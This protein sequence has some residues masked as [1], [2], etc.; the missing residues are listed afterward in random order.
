MALVEI[1]RPTVG[2]LGAETQRGLHTGFFQQATLRP[3]APA[4]ALADRE[5][6]YAEIADEA[7]RLAAALF[8][9]CNRP[10][11]RVGIFAYRSRASYAGTLGAL[12]AGAAFVPLNP[13]F[14]VERTRAMAETADLDA[15]V[16]DDGP[17]LGQVVQV[18][19]GLSRRPALLLPAA[20]LPEGSLRG[21][22]TLDP[23]A[24]AGIRPLRDLPAI[25]PGAPAYLL[26]T[27]GSTGEPKGIP[28]T[29]ANGVSFLTTSQRRYRFTPQDRLTQT[30]DATFDL[31]VFDLFMAW[32]SGACLC[33]IR[34]IE[35]LS[36][37]G[38]VRRQRITTW[39]SVPSVISLLVRKNLLLPGSLANL[40]WS[41]FCGEP[42]PV[43]SAQAWQAA[44]PDSLVENLY[45]PTELTIACSVYRWHTGRSE[46]ESVNGIVPI[47]RP[48]ESLATLVVDHNLE[49]VA[50][51]ETGELCVAG[52]Q[53]F[54]GYWKDPAKTEAAIFERMSGNGEPI[55][56]YRTGD[57]VRSIGNRRYVFLGRADQQIKILGHRV[58]LGE[59]ESALCALPG[60][61]EAVAVGRPVEGG[62]CDRVLAFVTG[63]DLDPRELIT[64]LRCRL[65]AYMAPS[66]VRVR[67]TM[68]LNANGKIDRRALQQL[69]MNATGAEVPR[70]DESHPTET[71]STAAASSGDSIP[72]TGSTI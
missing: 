46:A 30:F 44:A 22:V 61:A 12:L 1:D 68:P 23:A 28:I 63:H 11:R 41:L 50:A 3:R 67:A 66:E 43:S 32:G 2:R 25:D 38:F 27:S 8:E 69:A 64:S 16:V 47:G 39:F 36:P 31:S 9:A 37:F 6:A 54:P 19:A 7:R 57:I 56:Y 52:P 42:L 51:G 65:P 48:Y 53:V 21:V 60:V 15:I 18:L 62:A 5:W 4:L 13:T 70:R 10:P 40:R 20:P 45:G 33:P 26:F 24:I 55:R 35:L 49:P 72:V 14:P 58:E 34:P 17:A 59:I 29:H 71:T